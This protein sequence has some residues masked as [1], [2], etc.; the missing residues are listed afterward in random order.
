MIGKA[1][2]PSWTPR[3]YPI[4]DGVS[5]GMGLLPPLCLAVLYPSCLLCPGAACTSLPVFPLPVFPLPVL[6]L[7]V[8]PQ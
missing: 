7:P 3:L 5:Y 4:R 8:F 1:L 6:P 2:K